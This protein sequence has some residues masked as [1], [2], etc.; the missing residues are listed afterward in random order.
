MIRIHSIETCGT[1]D[2]PGI[3]F[4][5]FMQG[6]TLRCKYCH[7]PDTWE[8]N[9]GK[10]ISI[11]EL[12]SEIEKYKA[13]IKFSNGGVTISGGEPLLQAKELTILFK[14]CKENGIHTAI[15]TSGAIFNEDVC[16]MLR[17]VDLVLLDIKA[18]DKKIFKEV[19][20]ASNKKTGEFIKYISEKDIPIWI[21]YVLVPGLTDN[22][23]DIKQIGKYVETVNNVERLEVLPFHKMGEYKWKECGYE[24]TLEKTNEP[25]QAEVNRVK[26]ILS[27]YHN[28]V[29]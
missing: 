18:F 3:R 1:V 11:D 22:A 21:R 17:Y 10:E 23:E 12:F 24:Y 20:G 28:K 13:Y 6:C 7:N 15:D 8:L 9:H 25:T 5:A 4:V 19:T 14:K 27:R 16:E 2:G 26:E 29:L